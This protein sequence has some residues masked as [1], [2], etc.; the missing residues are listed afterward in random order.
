MKCFKQIHNTTPVTVKSMSSSSSATSSSSSSSADHTD[1][2]LWLKLLRQNSTRAVAAETTCVLVGDNDID[3]RSL[4]SVLGQSDPMDTVDASVLS[5]S[6]AELVGYDVF[7]VDE[8]ALDSTTKVHFWSF[9]ERVFQHSTEFLPPCMSN[10]VI[11]KVCR[12]ICT[13]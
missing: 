9:D 7:D 8:G 2:S 1:E 12:C 3:K 10:G 4:L 5:S 11:Q 13:R 6:L